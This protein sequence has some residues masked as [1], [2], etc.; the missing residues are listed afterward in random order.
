MRTLHSLGA[1]L[2]QA[3]AAAT[4]VPASVI[5]R[6]DVGRLTVGGAADI[7]VLD[8]QLEI[9]RVLVRGEECVTT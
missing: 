2:E 6:S 4:S 9:L 8:D 5:G 7:V 1:P 3:I